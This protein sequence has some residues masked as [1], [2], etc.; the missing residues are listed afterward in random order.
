MV[1]L[2]AGTS[3]QGPENSMH[4]MQYSNWG[5]HGEQH[6]KVWQSYAKLVGSCLC[7]ADFVPYRSCMHGQIILWITLL[8][9]PA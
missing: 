1:R 5:E 3:R 4:Q 9:T 8:P 2:S 7:K 6:K